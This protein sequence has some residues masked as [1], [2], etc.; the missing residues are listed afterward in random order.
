MKRLNFKLIVTTILLG[1]I[2][3]GSA[4]AMGHGGGGFHG[5]GFHGGS[6]FHGGFPH[7]GFDHGGFVHD[8]A[9]VDHEHHAR[10]GAFV[11]IGAPIAWGPAWWYYPP[12]PAY[13]GYPP[14]AVAAPDSPQ[15]YVE[16]G[17]GQP[18][19]PQQP[20]WYYC[21]DSKAYYPYVKE[22]SGGWQQVA[23]QPPPS[24]PQAA[25]SPP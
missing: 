16:Q 20:S 2:A 21:S 19:P 10:F 24:V 7:A 4:F 22:C 6:S 3:S 5:G 23:P 1:A 8:R 14:V 13:Y 12:P 17:D 11:G 15:A 18:A 25:A 9:F